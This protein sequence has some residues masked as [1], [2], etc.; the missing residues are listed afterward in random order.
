[1]EAPAAS[2]PH[3]LELAA[4]LATVSSKSPLASVMSPYRSIETAPSSERHTEQG[5]DVE[6]NPVDSSWLAHSTGPTKALPKHY[7]SLTTSLGPGRYSSNCACRRLTH[8]GRLA[9]LESS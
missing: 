7:H 4:P 8:A 1:M 9:K 5:N 3:G 6:T 2:F